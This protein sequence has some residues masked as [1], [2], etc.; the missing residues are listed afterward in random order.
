MSTSLPVPFSKMKCDLFV[1]LSDEIRAPIS[2]VGLYEGAK[3]GVV[4]FQ[5]RYTSLLLDQLALGVAQQ[6]VVQVLLVDPL[7][8]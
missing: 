8:C 3:S 6:P 5:G 4:S 2:L 1:L 7:M